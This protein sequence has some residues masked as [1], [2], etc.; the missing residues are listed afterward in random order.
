VLCGAGV[1]RARVEAVMR[2][3][4]I[5][6]DAEA[7]RILLGG[8]REKRCVVLHYEGYLE[9]LTLHYIPLAGP[10]KTGTVDVHLTVSS[11]KRL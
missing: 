6:D 8:D 9:I 11:T 7:M 2:T 5:I 1:A 10:E 4:A 3:A